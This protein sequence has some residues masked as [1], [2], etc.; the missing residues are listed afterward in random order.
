M[1]AFAPAALSAPESLRLTE[2]LWSE[3]GVLYPEVTEPPFPPKDI[4]GERTVFV[5]AWSGGQAIGCATLVIFSS[6]KSNGC[7]S[8]QVHAV[9]AFF[10]AILAKLEELAF[11]W[12]LRQVRL[13]IRHEQIFRLCAVYRVAESVPQIVVNVI[14]ITASPTP[15]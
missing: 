11:V 8:L 12:N 9:L 13:C 5:R 1:S 3:L 14:R 4:V 2:Q 15:A 6:A 7:L 10:P